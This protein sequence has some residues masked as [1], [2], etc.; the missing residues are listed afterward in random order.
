MNTQDAAPTAQYTVYRKAIFIIVPS[1]EDQGIFALPGHSKH[2]PRRMV[3]AAQLVDA[4][5]VPEQRE[6]LIRG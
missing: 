1:Y 4:G 5:F 6:L 2:T 3:T